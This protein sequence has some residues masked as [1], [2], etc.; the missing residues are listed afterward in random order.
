MLSCTRGEK[1][2]RLHLNGVLKRRKKA[3]GNRATK[4]IGNKQKINITT[5]VIDPS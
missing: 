4:K 2:N 5:V 3:E 1:E